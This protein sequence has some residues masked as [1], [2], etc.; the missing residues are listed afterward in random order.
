MLR[1]LQDFE[2]PFITNKHMHVM[3][4]RVV[5]GRNYWDVGYDV[6]LMNNSVAMNLLYIQAV[7][8]V[9]RGWILVTDELKNQLTTLQNYEKK[10]EV[11]LKTCYSMRNRNTNNHVTLL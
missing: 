4:S 8:E 11:C 2:S 6:K 7:A 9:Q 3:G 1:K 5:L 10:R